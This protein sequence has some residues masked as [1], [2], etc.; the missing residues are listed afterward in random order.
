MKSDENNRV[1][2]IGLDGGEWSV[3]NPL[4]ERGL[5]PNL[6]KLIFSGTS[7]DLVSSIPPITPTAWASFMTGVNPGKH[8]I[9]SY[10]KKLNKENSYFV[11]PLN[12]LDIQKEHLWHILGRHGKK[13]AF[14]NVPMSFPP[15]K[16]NGY[17][18]T[19]MMTPST[20]SRFTYPDSLKRELAENKINYRI[21]LEIG[22]EVNLLE[23][24]LFHENYFL[25]DKGERFFREL[26]G[27]TDQRS[28]AIK[29]LMKN[30]QW[31]F[32]MGV[33]IGMD[34]VQH[35][36]W[37]HLDDGLNGRMNQIAEKIFDYYSYLDKI[38]GELFLLTGDNTTIII[39]SDHGFGRY[40]GDF[41]INRWLLDQG[42]LSV[43]KGNRKFAPW[44]KKISRKLGLRREMLSKVINQKKMDSLRMSV[45]E[46]DWGSSRAFSALAHCIHINVKGRETLGCVEQGSEYEDLRER[47][48]KEL[49]KIKDPSTGEPVIKK[50]LKREDVYN[51][52]E[53]E[54]APDLIVLSSDTDHYG[55]Y[56]TRHSHDGIFYENTWKTGDHRQNGIFV[57][58]GKGIKSA[59]TIHNAHIIDVLPTILYVHD[60]PIPEYVDGK[61]LKEVFKNPEKEIRIE[62]TAEHNNKNEEYTYNDEETE[63][64]K[65]RLKQLGYID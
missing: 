42:F 9:F 11:S 38:I 45:Q 7:G 31:D 14:V 39:M 41:L 56:S 10:Q 19:G 40:K 47:I 57:I 44:L 49:Y 6:Q 30:K 64:V 63:D 20:E 18:I 13:V 29:Y 46:I 58:S 28:D 4:M 34:R 53:F 65:D 5:L 43:K 3:L 15:Q 1:M 22:K 27:I 32:F 33:F 37:Q 8:G 51:G 36:L 35:Y 62:H 26:Y 23:D 61:V 12:S 60:L 50:V 59:E 17:M 54:V 48:I 2:V 52:S 55:I 24:P 16:V 21:D 25:K